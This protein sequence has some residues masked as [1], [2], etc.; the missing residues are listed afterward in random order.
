MSLPLVVKGKLLAAEGGVL[1]EF[2][3]EIA[4]AGQFFN[5]GGKPKS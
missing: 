3:G 1:E 5:A 4:D 2:W